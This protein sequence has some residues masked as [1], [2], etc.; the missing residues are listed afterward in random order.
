MQFEML[1]EKFASHAVPPLP[2]M[3]KTGGSSPPGRRSRAGSRQF[4]AFDEEPAPYAVPSLP[5]RLGGV[6][7][8]DFETRDPD[9]KRHGPGWF[10]GGDGEVAGFSLAWDGGVGY[11]PLRHAGGGN[12][13]DP[14][15]HLRWL[16]DQ[17]EGNPDCVWVAHNASYELGWLTAESRRLRGRELRRPAGGLFHDTWLMS[18]TL[19]DVRRQHGLDA[20]MKS[21]LGL[22][23]KER[24]IHAGARRLGINPKDNGAVKSALWRMP[25]AYVATYGE[26]DAQGSLELH[27]LL[28]RRL[29]EENLERAYDR[30]RRLCHVLVE[31]RTRGVLVDTERAEV[32]RRDLEA[33]EQA[34]QEE[35][36]R[37]VGRAVDVWSAESL[38]RAFDGQ[39]VTDYP[40]TEKGQP[41]FTKEWLDARAGDGERLSHLVLESRRTHK[42]RTTFI[43][44]VVLGHAIQG[45]IFPEVNQV[46]RDDGTGGTDTGRFSYSNPNLQFLPAR[47]GESARLVR[48]LL[49]PDEG[50]SRWI[51]ADYSQQEPRLTVHFSERLG[52]RGAATFA[53][54][55]RDDPGT[56][57]HSL[58]ASISGLPRKQAKDLGLAVTYG[59]G[60][61]TTCRKLG[62]PTVLETWTG[63]DGVE[64]TTERPGP[65]GEAVIDRF[66]T[67]L[68]FL[69]EIDEQARA[70][71][72]TR[73]HIVTLGG[74]RMRFMRG[75]DGLVWASEVRKALNKLIQGS[76]ADQTKEALILAWE[77]GINIKVQVHDELCASGDEAAAERLREC[78]A[79][80]LPL[81]VPSLVDVA[82]GSNWGECA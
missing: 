63:R 71:A 4:D 11:W 17:V 31:M 24:L 1:D 32:L 45:R 81:D 72:R 3:R 67:E 15:R 46:R 48:G 13:E 7:G 57:F 39:G 29:G 74:R 33:K 52:A 82:T 78:M 47:R 26:T 66:R 76:A 12:V 53:Q 34:L 54:R 70:V 59:Q 55:Y 27:G 56:D 58:T 10:P 6:V 69:A 5:D 16:I 9:L 2:A 68:P 25:A 61:G 60:D 40:K 8:L 64:R 28:D 20:L 65:E 41:S 21:E 50:D 42:N 18:V 43:E 38:K 80:A 49:V 14:E 23:K 79:A 30:E 35:T 19:D 22:Q 77:A 62:Y 37:L 51:S 44:G 73:G 75:D 36:R